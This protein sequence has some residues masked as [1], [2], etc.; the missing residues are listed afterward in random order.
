[1]K[2]IEYKEEEI[3]E[4]SGRY[5]PRNSGSSKNHS[6]FFARIS[7]GGERANARLMSCGIKNVSRTG[8]ARGGKAL[9]L[10]LSVQFIQA[11]YFRINFAGAGQNAK[12]RRPA[13]GE[14][15]GKINASAR[16]R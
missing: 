11:R 1:M 10:Q 12:A 4:S 8:R 3:N 9:E 15:R 2:R 7:V 16:E 14:E 6:R 5:V 13:E